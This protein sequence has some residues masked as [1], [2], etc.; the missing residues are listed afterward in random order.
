MIVD[1]RRLSFKNEFSSS[2]KHLSLSS[3]TLCYVPV[4]YIHQ[5][6]ISSLGTSIR[7]ISDTTHTRYIKGNKEEYYTYLKESDQPEHNPDLFDKLIENLDYLGVGWES[8]YILCEK[9]DNQYFILDGAHRAAIL[10]NRGAQ[11]ILCAVL[12]EENQ[13]ERY[14]Q[15][16]KD[17]W[18]S[19]YQ[20]VKIG[21]LVINERTYP[22]YVER[23]EFLTNGERGQSKFELTV[24]PHVNFEGKN[25]VDLGCNS[26]VIDFAIIDSGAKSV[27]GF[28]RDHSMDQPTN[29]EIRQDYVQ[30][31]WFVKNLYTLYYG[32]KYQSISFEYTDLTDI[33]LIEDIC[34]KYQGH[35][36]MSLCVLYHFDN[37]ED[38]IK[39]LS[40]YTNEIILQ[41]NLGH[42][43]ELGIRVSV[44]YH[45]EVLKTLGGSVSVYN[46]HSKY[47][48]IVWNR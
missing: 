25:I 32:D 47:P 14:A 23:P 38:I 11:N 44:G 41:T 37:M 3:Y 36:I 8:N 22:S 10:F 9:R 48:L 26:G 6:E 15:D 34:K 12:C 24:K 45:A 19:W 29:K 7:H 42:G 27:I 31:A 43:G 1:H 16:F 21:S 17:H 5:E 28:D 13:F 2:V 4:V 39:L 35:T 30:Q 40:K 18:K 46:D 33:N 20:P